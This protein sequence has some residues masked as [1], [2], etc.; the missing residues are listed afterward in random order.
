MRMGDHPAVWTNEKVKARNVY[1]IMGHHAELLRS[2]DFTTMFGN[3]IL[4]ASGAGNWF[5]R[6]RMLIHV[7]DGVEPAHREFAADAVR[8]FR[9][10]T[11]GDGFVVDTTNNADDLND[12]KLRTYHVVVS[13]NDN[14]GHTEAQRAAFR[15]YMETA[16][17]G[18]DSTQPPTTTLRRDG[19]GLPTSWEAACSTATTGRPCPQSSRLTTRLI[20]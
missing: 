15:R 14:P 5:P 9:D 18:W 11:I 10:M 13:V 8:F 19:R 17:H 2:K 1:F 4:W 16:G 20:L 6:F 3:A 12:E 7:N